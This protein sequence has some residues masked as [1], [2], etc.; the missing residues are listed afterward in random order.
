MLR[1]QPCFLTDLTS[2]VLKSMR[3]HD[4]QACGYNV[5]E[6][7]P[8][9]HACLSFLT[10]TPSSLAGQAILGSLQATSTDGSR[11]NPFD[12]QRH[13]VLR[14]RPG[15]RNPRSVVARRLCTS[16][17]SADFS[18]RSQSRRFRQ[19]W[20]LPRATQPCSVEAVRS[21]HAVAQS[22][23]MTGGGK[24][25]DIGRLRSNCNDANVSH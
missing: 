20:L 3:Y 6:S 22:V 10:L 2:L 12:H 25:H 17:S 1:S 21:L 5:L 23:P 16:S 18:S 15:G 14:I 13:E 24:F 11:S 9:T 7:C 8:R 19:S 4:S